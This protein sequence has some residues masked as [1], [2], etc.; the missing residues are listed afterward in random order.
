MTLL[1]VEDKTYLGAGIASP[2]VPWGEAVTSDEPKGYGYNFVWSRDLYQ[3]FT[4]FEAVGD[5]GHRRGRSRIHLR[6]P[7]GQ[8]RVHPTEHLP[9]R[10]N[11]LGRRA[12]GQHLVPRRHGVIA[13]PRAASTSR[14]SSTAT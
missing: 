9:Q 1:A 8:T 3:V 14:T 7:A 11:P 12:D 6:V 5:A 4:V 2:S 10:T 13:S